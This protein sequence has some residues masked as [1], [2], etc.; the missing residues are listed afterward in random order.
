MGTKKLTY[1]LSFALVLIIVP[2]LVFNAIQDKKQSDDSTIVATNYSNEVNGKKETEL[3]KKGEPNEQESPTLNN[4]DKKDNEEVAIPTPENDVSEN[5]TASTKQEE[6]TKQKEP[7]KSETNNQTATEPKQQPDPPKKKE[8]V[9]TVT[10]KVV[11]PE[12]KGVILQ[13]AKV[14]IKEGDT[15]L[16]SLIAAAKANG[17]SVEYTG[18]GSMAYIEG[19]AN[20]Y[21]FDYGPT[22]GWLCYLNGQA[23]PKSSGTIKVKNGDLIEWKYTKD[24]GAE[25]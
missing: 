8:Q 7:A 12:E 25:S 11:G 21:E 16:S 15:V 2:L 17:F 24:F 10:V 1:L 9:D 18:S 23:L 5:K 4:T 20:I 14:L 6:E 22:S 3:T 19:I 13:G